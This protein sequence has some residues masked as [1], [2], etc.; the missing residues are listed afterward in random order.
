MIRS[1]PAAAKA[2]RR[3]PGFVDHQVHVKRDVARTPH[4]L[5]GDGPEGQ[6]GHVVAVHHVEVEPVD[7]V[8]DRLDLVGEA[9]EVGGE[10]RRSEL[11][12]PT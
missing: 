2:G 8:G 6:V 11:K 4:R 5:D 9:S 1:A 12:S 3:T 7:V 10:D